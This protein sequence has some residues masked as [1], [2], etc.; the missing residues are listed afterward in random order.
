LYIR[1]EGL[2]TNLD[3]LAAIPV[4]INGNTPILIRDVATV[5]FAPALRYGAMTMNGQGEVVGGITLM[6]KG[7]NSYQVVQRVKQRI[8]DMEKSLP[9]GVSNRTLPGS[10]RFDQQNSEHG[11]QKPGRRRA[12]CDSCIYCSY[13][14]IGARP[15]SWLP[16]FRS[17][18]SL[19]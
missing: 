2:I 6:L 15:S 13:W 4:A 18:C 12:H 19:P 10:Q 16:S 5:R 14:A 11:N 17:P 3:D 7:A 8:A 1:S 9:V